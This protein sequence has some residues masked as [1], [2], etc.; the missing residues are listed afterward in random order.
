MSLTSPTTAAVRT[1]IELKAT[2]TDADIQVFIDDAVLL[3]EQCASVAAMS[4]TKQAAVIKWITAHLMSFRFG[5][6]GGVASETLGDASRSYAV[7]SRTYGNDLTSSFYGQQA[8]LLDSTGCLKRL[9][10]DKITFQKV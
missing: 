8:I 10:R 1:A 9:G 6:A 7:G 2:V 3:A 4:A 5:A